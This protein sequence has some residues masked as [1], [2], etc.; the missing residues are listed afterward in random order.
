M[1]GESVNVL[2]DGILLTCALAVLIIPLIAWMHETPPDQPSRP[3]RDQQHHHKA[4]APPEL[5]WH[6]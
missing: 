2:A 3:E 6:D 4:D 5:T 1:S